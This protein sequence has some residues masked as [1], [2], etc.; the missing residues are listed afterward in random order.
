MAYKAKNL[1]I[2]KARTQG[3]KTN[4]LSSLNDAI[5]SQSDFNQGLKDMDK[6]KKSRMSVDRNLQGLLALSQYKDFNKQL[7]M[8]EYER[9]KTRFMG[10]VDKEGS[11]DYTFPTFDDFYE[12]RAIGTIGGVEYT[13]ADTS[14][15]DRDL[16]INKLNLLLGE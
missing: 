4:T 3:A 6:N 1:S 14:I 11:N 10:L 7:S 2:G 8:D 15:D 5:K 12:S 9:Y 16:P 13:P